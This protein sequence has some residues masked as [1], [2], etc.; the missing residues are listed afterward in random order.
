MLDDDIIEPATKS[1]RGPFALL[2]TPVKFEDINKECKNVI[3]TVE[4][5]DGFRFEFNKTISDEPTFGISHSIGMGSVLEPASYN[6]GTNFLFSKT[7]MLSGRV[8]TDGHVMG[9][10]QQDLTTNT[11]LKVSAQASPEPHSSA[12]HMEVEYKGSYWFG[13]V[14]WG[15]P[16]IYG[17]SY[18]QS[19]TPSL[20]IGLDTF[21]HHK[22]AMSLLTA[23]FRYDTPTSTTTGMMT[24]G[25]IVSSYVYKIGQRVNLATELTLGFPTGSLETSSSFGV[26]YMLRTSH[27]KCHVDTNWKVSCYLEE[28]LNQYTRFMLCGELD[29]K[30]KS[31]RFGFGVTMAM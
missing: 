20:S 24:T 3:G 12:V 18:M 7:G 8:D 23:G 28:M 11:S 17:I 30:K 2:P 6:L 16:G 31:Y 19:V 25:H 22:Q 26:D 15:N 1:K 13:N 4:L 5:F 9:R 27:I 14:K 29:H 10:F 21:Y